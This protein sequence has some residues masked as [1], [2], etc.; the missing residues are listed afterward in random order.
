MTEKTQLQSLIC[1]PINLENNFGDIENL[2]G[3]FIDNWSI[4]EVIGKGA[5]GYVYRCSTKTKDGTFHDAAIKFE[6]K[7]SPGSASFLK[8]E[9]TIL[10]KLAKMGNMKNFTTLYNTGERCNFDYMIMTLLGPNLFDICAFLPGEKMEIGT[11]VRVVYQALLAIQSLHEIKYIHL[12][13]KPANFALG[14]RNDSIR[15]QILHLLDFGLSRKYGSRTNPKIPIYSA[16]K[17]GIEYV[18]TVT[19]CSP[20]A[21]SRVE[22]SRRDD[23]WSWLFM[24]IDLYNELP[25]RE[26]QDDQEIENFKKSATYQLYCDSLPKHCHIII[27]HIMKLG[28]YDYPDYELCFTH[29]LA[30]IKDENVKIT[31]PYQWEL[32]PLETKEILKLSCDSQLKI[33]PILENMQQKL[34][35]LSKETKSDSIGENLKT[36]RINNVLIGQLQDKINYKECELEITQEDDSINENRDKKNIQKNTSTELKLNKKKKVAKDQVGNCIKIRYAKKKENVHGEIQKDAINKKSTNSIER[37]KNKSQNSIEK[38]IILKQNQNKSTT[39]S[40]NSHK[41]ENVHKVLDVLPQKK[42]VKRRRHFKKLP[43]VDYDPNIMVKIQ[44]RFKDNMLEKC[45][46]KIKT[47]EIIEERIQK[48]KNP[49][50][51]IEKNNDDDK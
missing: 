41:N 13:I 17:Q 5:F 50:I 14:H 35:L 49:I 26:K 16:P 1:S 47:N 51:M 2:E 12:D 45:N 39:K 18:G 38:G 32:L 40:K 7:Q 19:H 24:C 30:I 33:S 37:R 11:W 44:R 27:D 20:Y 10:L 22:L 21:H 31:D 15:C 48:E 6:K 42:H 46:D 36:L 25:W 34:D 4:H 8:M 29:L 23:M 43:A 3:L 28:T 9:C